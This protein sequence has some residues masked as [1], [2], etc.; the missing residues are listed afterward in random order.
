VQG[1]A[2]AAPFPDA[3]FD[4]VWTQHIS[5]NIADK[6]GLIRELRRLV[7]PSGR[8]VMHEITAGRVQ[9]IHLPVPWAREPAASHLASVVELRW[10]LARGGLRE[11]AWVDQSQLSLE[12]NRKRLAA[13]SDVTRPPGLELLLGPDFPTMAANQVRNLEEDRIGVVMTVWEAPGAAA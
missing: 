13:L 9:P 7:T 3:T 6:P 12:F 11:L 8:L 2:L 4:V 5:M 1:D 10:L